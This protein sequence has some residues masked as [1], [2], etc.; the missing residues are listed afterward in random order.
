MKQNKFMAKTVAFLLC[1]SVLV[2]NPVFTGYGEDEDLTNQLSGIQQQM[3]E[4]QSKASNAQAVIVSVSEQ[5]KQIQAELDQAT[6][7]L[8]NIET[9]RIAVEAEIAQNEKRLRDAQARLKQREGVF[10]KRVRDIYINGRLSYLDVIIGSKDFSDFATRLDLLKRIIDADITLIK[11]IQKEREEI[12]AQRAALEANRAKLVTLEKEAKDKKAVIDQK[13]AERNA[14]LERART[15]KA[16][17]EQA[18]RELEAASNNIR[19]MLRQREEARRQQQQQAQSSG[20]GGGGY[21][22]GTGQFMWPV[23][24]VITSPFGWRTHPIFGRQILHSGIDIGVD[25]GTVVHAADSGTV[26]YSGWISG[27]GYAVIIDHG[28]GLSTLYGHNSGLIVSEGQS[29][30]KGEPIAY[31]GSTGNSTGPHVHF[32]VRQNGDP[33]DPLGYL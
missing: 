1:T 33:V 32:E 18:Q 15:D 31:A 28:N 17:A 4:Q 6:A 19:E 12:E 10:Y 20:G 22:Q 11:E 25:E 9:Q 13:K 8:K 21:V 29:V 7:E 14:V 30:S 5:L 24:G 23:Q 2:G 27:Y 16:A 26:V 3:Q